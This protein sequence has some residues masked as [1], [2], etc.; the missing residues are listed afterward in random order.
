MPPAPGYQL[1]GG[2][3]SRELLDFLFA[4]RGMKLAG[5]DVD[6]VSPPLDVAHVTSLAALKFVFE[7]FAAA[8]LGR[9]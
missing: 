2:L 9:A 7:F 1:R 8:K 4:L 6:E 3:S 5:I